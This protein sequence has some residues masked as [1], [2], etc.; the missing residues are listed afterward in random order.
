[1]IEAATE[2]VLLPIVMGAIVGVAVVWWSVSAAVEGYRLVRAAAD[3]HC[4]SR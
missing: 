3:S 1:M 4:E 2:I